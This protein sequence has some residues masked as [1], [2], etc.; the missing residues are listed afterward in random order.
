[1]KKHLLFVFAALLPLLTSAHDF[2]VNGIYYN[3]TS[4]TEQTVAV[5]CR[6]G[7]YNSYYN[8]YKGSVTIPSTVTYLS[9]FHGCSKLKK[10]LTLSSSSAEFLHGIPY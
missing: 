3:I 10:V 6:G 2:E 8:E 1:M 4:S 9:G 5:T 7:S